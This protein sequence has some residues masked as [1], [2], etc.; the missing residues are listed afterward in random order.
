MAKKPK[1]SKNLAKDVETKIKRT[2]LMLR[3]AEVSIKMNHADKEMKRQQVIIQGFN[4]QGSGI[5]EEIEKLD[6]S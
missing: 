1:A 4:Q 3:L 6:D 2:R 5:L